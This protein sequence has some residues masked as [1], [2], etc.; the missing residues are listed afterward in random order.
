MIRT[1]ASGIL[2][3]TVVM[4]G[5][6]AAQESPARPEAGPFVGAEVCTGCHDRYVAAWSETK[7]ARAFDRLGAG[8]R[9]NVQCLRCH[10]TGPAERV[11][12]EGA[13]PSLPGVQCEACHGAGRPHVEAAQSGTARP[14]GIVR[15]PAESACT[16]CH[17]PQSPH[18]K[19]FFYGAMAGLV[20]RVSR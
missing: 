1:L 17:N 9:E 8:A 2:S 12:A 5:A 10:V 4:A 6:L 14:A 16:Q 18:Y 20:H 19:P 7:H 15:R 11:A 13:R 3:A